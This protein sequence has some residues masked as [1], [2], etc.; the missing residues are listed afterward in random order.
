MG[1]AL[2]VARPLSG[3]RWRRKSC[4][5]TPRSTA[6][7]LIK[8]RGRGEEEC[9]RGRRRRR[10]ALGSLPPPLGSVV[11]GSPLAAG[12]NRAR[13]RTR[14]RHGFP[15]P[16]RSHGTTPKPLARAGFP[17]FR[18]RGLIR[19]RWWFLQVWDGRRFAPCF[20]DLYPFS[21]S[22][23]S[24]SFCGWLCGSCCDDRK[25]FSGFAVP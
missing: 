4:T 5:K 11:P 16:R 25:S 23:S 13:A 18:T 24:F 3:G 6:H 7:S 20:A 21:S 1:P 2:D 9:V 19:T 22:Y 10:H 17:L 12:P 14:R 15:L 8:R